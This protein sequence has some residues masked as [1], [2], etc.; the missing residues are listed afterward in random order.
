METFE[1]TW[2]DATSS[3]EVSD[4][5]EWLRSGNEALNTIW[6]EYKDLDFDTQ[7]D[8][9]GAKRGREQ[10]PDDFD[11][12]TNMARLYANEIEDELKVWNEARVFELDST[13]IIEATQCLKNVV[14]YGQREA[15]KWC[16]KGNC[17]ICCE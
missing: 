12:A 7:G 16:G 2:G 10:S 3:E 17:M 8:E 11:L 6:E 5:K 9:A 4:L 1:H 13:D 15:G 14:D